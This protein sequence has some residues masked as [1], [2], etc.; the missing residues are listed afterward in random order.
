MKFAEA[1]MAD[2]AVH[3][4]KIGDLKRSKRN[5]WAESVEE[6]VRSLSPYPITYDVTSIQKPAFSEFTYTEFLNGVFVN[7]QSA[8][9]NCR[10]MDEVS[11]EDKDFNLD[12]FRD[13]VV[14]KYVL[15]NYPKKH[16]LVAFMPGHN[17]L[18][19][20]SVELLDR[21]T[22]EYDDLMI[23]IH[24]NTDEET[25]KILSRRYGYNKIIKGEASGIELLKNCKV[26]FTTTAS[27]M[28]ILATILGIRTVNLSTFKHESFGAYY[29]IARIIYT[30]Q[31]RFGLEESRRKLNNI[32]NS[33]KC[34]LVFPGDN[35]EERLI[36]YYDFALR[37][38]DQYKPLAAAQVP[39]KAKEDQKQT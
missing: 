4:E 27:E 14:D 7:T 29:A 10:V 17:L 23:K 15:K 19:L 33:D 21:Y 3:L 13:N 31:F 1:R 22:H 12:K 20:S 5:E 26:A 39:F 9:M 16:D 28:G 6:I 8:E 30:T 2:K 35:V 11:K 37:I 18:D 34:G 32:L 24:P 36:N 25:T 38:R